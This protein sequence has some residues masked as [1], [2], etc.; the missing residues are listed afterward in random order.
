MKI[1]IAIFTTAVLAGLHAAQP[2]LAQPTRTG[3]NLNSKAI[4]SEVLML[5]V[6]DEV[7]TIRQYLNDGRKNDALRAAQAYIE[8]V[9]RLSLRHESERK[10][11]AWNAYCTVLTSLQRVE[12][13]IAACTTAMA[14]EPGKWS[15]VNNRGT[16][17]F[18][19]GRLEEALSDYRAAMALVADDNVQ[20]RETINHNI[21]LVQD[22]LAG[23]LN[24]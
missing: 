9:E 17:K 7:E 4:P 14:F 5:Q 20:V 23:N 11:Y 1:G 8:E 12:D 22:R 13:A 24:Q 19:G 2:A 16:A 15:A 18:V 10:Y 3:T 21:S 6:P